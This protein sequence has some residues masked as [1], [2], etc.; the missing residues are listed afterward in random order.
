MPINV[1][2][3]LMR[4][5]KTYEVVSQVILQAVAQGRRV[6]TN[7][8][9]ISNDLIRDYAGQK[10]GLESEKLGSVIHVSNADVFKE[11]FFPYYDDA[12][13]VHTDTIV[14]PGDLVCIDE[15]WRF[16]PAS[17]GKIHKNHQSFFLEHGHFTNENT[18]VACDL[19]LMI[20]DMGTL[21]RSLKTVV[22]FNF[23]THKKVSLGLSNTYS[24]SMFEGYKQTKQTQ[25]GNWVRTYRK[26]IFPLYS[27]FN[28]GIEGKTVN[29]D[30]RQNIF[31]SKRL[32]IIGLLCIVGGGYS[33][34][35]LWNYFH[36]Q[37]INEGS[38]KT[39]PNI[40]G[41]NTSDKA[42][43]HQEIPRQILRNFSENWRISGSFSS[44]GNSYVV[45]TNSA[46]AIRVES[47]SVFHNDGYAKLGEIDGERV[48]VWSG[49]S[50]QNSSSLSSAQ[51]AQSSFGGK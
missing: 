22:A 3:G 34:N 40:G 46:G 7:V 23:R 42:N 16:W 27:S 8:D 51:P 48:T 25:I 29:V 4:S 6:V 11:D 47:P 1:Y 41:G 28:G 9:G 20:Q 14:Q 50:R 31:S 13:D 24:I 17:G 21:H 33:A 30:S 49:V 5:G 18:G 10:Y 12:K 39:T 19:V 44:N 15:A 26:E 38:E 2:T 36:P 45:V 35:N 32:W 37:K 43:L